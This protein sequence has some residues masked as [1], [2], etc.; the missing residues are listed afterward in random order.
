MVAGAFTPQAGPP[1][2]TFSPQDEGRRLSAALYA[3][4]LPPGGPPRCALMNGPDR[5][6]K[7]SDPP[8]GHRLS[9]EDVRDHLAGRR[10]WAAALRD[11]EGLAV[12]GC[13]DYDGDDGEGAA[14]GLQALDAAA[15]ASLT[16]FAILVAGRAHVWAFYR[17]PA[18]AA[19]IAHQL[20]TLLPA[21]PG[22]VYPSGNNIR[23]PL[24]YHRRA[25][26]RG[27]LVLC[28]GQRFDLDRPADLTDGL[29][30]ILRLARNAAP[31]EAPPEARRRSSGNLAPTDP[32]AWDGLDAAHGGRIWA[33]SRY[34]RIL[35]PNH[36]QLG[37][38]ARGGRVAL[39][40]DA[41]LDDSDSAQLAAL[42]FNLIRAH[43]KGRPAGDGAPPE[44]EIRAVALHL[45]PQLQKAGESEARYCWRVDYEI[46]R[47]RPE[48]YRPEATTSIATMA[49][50]SP[51]PLPTRPGRPAGQ[52]AAHGDALAELLAQKLGQVVT[53]A[54][55]AQTLD[56]RPR[57]LGLYLADLRAADRLD[58]ARAGRGLR[59]LR[60][61]IKCPAPVE[62][63]AEAP[64]EVAP[65]I[66]NRPEAEE[67]AEGIGAQQIAIAAPMQGIHPPPPCPACPA[68]AALDPPPPPAAPA[69]CPVAA[70]AVP[71]PARRLDLAELLDLEA[72]ILDAVKLIRVERVERLDTGTG[73][74]RTRPARATLPRVAALLPDVAADDLAQGW[75]FYGDVWGRERRRLRALD[76]RKLAS[77]AK[78]AAK[79]HAEALAREEARA[80]YYA[81]M[82]ALADGEC[83]RRGL[84]PLALLDADLRRREGKPLDPHAPSIRRQPADFE[85][86]T[87]RAA[88]TAR[89]RAALLPL[90]DLAAEK[91][92]TSAPAAPAWAIPPADDGAPHPAEV[93][94]VPRAAQ[95][96]AEQP[97]PIPA[98][99]RVALQ[100]PPQVEQPPQVEP[101]GYTADECDAWLLANGWRRGPGGTWEPKPNHERSYHYAN[102]AD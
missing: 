63:P 40:K 59:I 5:D 47:Y 45:K 81:G 92:A 89:R 32:A 29:R 18:P 60:S 44:A 100:R 95:V 76:G 37:I 48:T 64:A 74:V 17:R 102:A 16:G 49:P 93:A 54:D 20:A 8:K 15:S 33:S 9:A 2:A 58:T 90:F 19:D 97:R 41:T 98:R 68:P 22:E 55:L 71:A 77:A 52:R 66:C 94:A 31:P 10:T 14:L 26:T 69:A 87:G 83:Q 34:T 57:M 67:A 28:D 75:A 96:E 99:P 1:P 82:A 56:V 53:T 46:T 85:T 70:P 43:R 38:I 4:V 51:G 21:G 12:A 23:L 61:A 30:A 7:Y 72:R 13:R 79:R 11:A 78:A 80:P 84:D 25:L 3:A 27:T 65:P 24:G 101:T 42:V 73:E 91:S 39:L 88:E 62:P 36:D 86:R 50:A 6:R 35:I